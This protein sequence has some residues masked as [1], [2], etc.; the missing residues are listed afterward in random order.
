MICA[1]EVRTFFAMTANT[2]G[3]LARS[4]AEE[5]DA[6]WQIGL[7][8]TKRPSHK[9]TPLG[10]IMEEDIEN[11]VDLPGWDAAGKERLAAMVV[12]KE[13]GMEQTA[14]M[15]RLAQLK[16]LLPGLASRMGT[17]RTA[18]LARL[19]MR[20]PDVAAQ[21]VRLRGV[22]SSAAADVAGMCAQEPALLEA[23]VGA[24]Q[25]RLAALRPLLPGVDVEALAS[26][27]PRVL[28]VEDTQDALIELERLLPPGTSIPQMV[29]QDPDLLLSVQKGK[30]LILYDNGSEAQVRASLK[31]R[32]SGDADG[33]GDASPEGW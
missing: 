29:A 22:F 25:A 20:V 14:I 3:R 24:L 31:A 16:I 15:E 27:A 11:L 32:A 33:A 21:L 5:A 1:E 13:L 6:P 26:V 17:M 2:L 19:A 8:Y 10:E 30:N 23:D 9:T 7:Y 4:S 28:N 12:A 18:D